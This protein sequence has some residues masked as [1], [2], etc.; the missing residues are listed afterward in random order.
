MTATLALMAFGAVMVFSATSATLAL[1]HRSST[2][3][4][5]RYGA[6]ASL[7]LIAMLL[8]TRLP[9]A[10]LQ[11]L[12][13]P[14][15]FAA[16]A[17][18]LLVLVPGVGLQVNGGR[19][20]LGASALQLQPSELMK[21]ALVLYAALLLSTRHQR[22]KSH[23]TAVRPL[24]AISAV[25]CALV[26]LEPDLGT[27]LVIALAIGCM[28]AVA[29]VSGRRLLVILAVAAALI[30][31]MAVAQPY[32]MARLTSFLDP[33]HTATTTGFQAVQG[34]IALG[35]GGLTGRGVGQSVQK[36]FYLPAAPTDF[37]L[38][39]IGEETGT[40]GICSLLAL[41][42]MLTLG[43]LRIARRAGDPYQQL[44]AVGATSVISC[45]ALLNVFVVLGLA[46]LTGV[47]LP[48]VSYGS[49]NLVVVLA[50]VGILRGV[51]RHGHALA[52]REPSRP[53]AATQRPQTQPLRRA[54]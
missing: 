13:K 34:Q 9:A 54:S 37:I 19:R 51:D 42:G 39:V 53:P 4:L 7:G 48:F 35:S 30:A 40:L 43:G 49:S 1:Q 24:L 31:V 33:W 26:V 22:L 11:R 46:P 38:A 32:K 15:L 41:Y 45:Q 5:L 29:G 28:L 2:S 14:L 3:Y 23:K 21:G 17:L 16:L 25:S 20:W 50:L 47:P 8:T 6:S 18:L 36:A 12:T 52:R 10:Q 44:L 27:A